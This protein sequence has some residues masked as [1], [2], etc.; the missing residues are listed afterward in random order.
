MSEML[1]AGAVL[2]LAYVMGMI[3]YQLSRIANVMERWTK[4]PPKPSADAF[5][6]YTMGD[7]TKGKIRMDRP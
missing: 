3:A 7:G 1:I 2:V 4:A 6:Q 5:L